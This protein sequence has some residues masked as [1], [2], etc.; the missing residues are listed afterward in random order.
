L[1]FE[2]AY[3]NDTISYNLSFTDSGWCAHAAHRTYPDPS[4]YVVFR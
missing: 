4:T 3:H 1:N 2:G